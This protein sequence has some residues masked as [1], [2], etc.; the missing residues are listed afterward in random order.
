MTTSKVVVGATLPRVRIPPSPNKIGFGFMP[1][2]ILFMSGI[3]MRTPKCESIFIGFGGF[4][5]GRHNVSP[6]SEEI[7]QT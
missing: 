6:D 7:E 3:G 5:N 2:P 4:P 1:R